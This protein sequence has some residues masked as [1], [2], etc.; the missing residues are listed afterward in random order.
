MK[1]RLC[2]LTC[3]SVLAAVSCGGDGGPTTPTETRIISLSGDINFGEV[4]VGQSADR[5][6]RITNTGNAPLTV[7]HMNGSQDL[8]A[9]F[10]T[11]LQSATAVFPG[12]SIDVLV[13]FR[14]SEARQY[15]AVA[16]VQGNMTSGTNSF[17][18][19]GIGVVR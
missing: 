13:Q 14:P 2:L 16:N 4:E 15:L 11:S 10:F 9:A 8:V 17:N 19:S 3:L 1:R 5:M 12:A 7:T 6:L 18:V